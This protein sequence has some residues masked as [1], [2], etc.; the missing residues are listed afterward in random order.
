[1][2]LMNTA[3]SYGSLTRLLHWLLAALLIG[4]LTIGLLLDNIG[5]PLVYQLHKLTGLLV[6]TVA[7]ANIIWNL[8]NVRPGYPVTVSRVQ[9]IVAKSVQHLMLLGAVLM[10]L[11]GWIFSTAAGK[12][13]QIGGLILAMPGISQN[14][15]LLSF[16]RPMHTY[17]A[18]TLIA[19]ISMHVLAA[20]AHHFILKDDILKKMLKG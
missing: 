19:L 14:P 16:F 10:P 17:V 18:Y 2:S 6:L 15:E 7:L 20:F 4:M 5:S 13:P 8:F 3:T 11:S 9:Q 12:P 1:M